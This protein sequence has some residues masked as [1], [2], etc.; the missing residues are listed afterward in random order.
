LVLRTDLSGDPTFAELLE[1]IRE[2]AL[3]AYAH[4]DLPFEKLVEELAIE[5][6]L[7]H[8]PA[9]QVMFVLQNTPG[10]DLAMSGLAPAALA[11]PTNEVSV[12]VTMDLT[13]TPDGLVASLVYNADLFDEA[14]ME[15]LLRHYRNVL[16]EVTADAGTPLGRVALL[17]DDEL[18]TLVEGFNPQPSPYPSEARVQEVLERLAA[19]RPDAVAVVYEDGT[20]TYGELNARANALARHLVDSGVERGDLVAVALDRGPELVTALLAVLKTGAAYLPIDPEH[21]RRRTSF[22]MDDA[23]AR[24]LL[25]SDDLAGTFDAGPARVVS[26]GGDAAAIAALSQDDLG[27]AGDSEDVAYAIYTSGSTGTPKGICIPH[28]AITRLVLDTDY[29]KLGPDS[30]VAQASN[31]SFDAATFE[32][33][34][35]LLNGGR[36]VGIPKD[37]LLDARRL[38]AALE[39]HDVGVM[40]VTTALFNQLVAEDPSLF[41]V[42]DTLLFGG[43]AVDPG[44]VRRCVEEG[45]PRELLHVY[46]PTESTTFTTWHR[47]ESVPDGSA[48]IPIGRPLANTRVHILDPAMNPVPAGVTGEIHIGGAGLATGY[49][50]RPELT[51]ERFVPDPLS[52]GPSALLYRTGDL[53]RYLPS[54]EIEFL[55]RIDSQVKIRGFRV[56][57]G[58]I[59]TVM[60]EH[61]AVAEAVV[62]VASG[63][64]GDRRLIGYV[65]AGADGFDLAELRRFLTERIPFYMVPSDFVRLDAFPLNANGKIDRRALPAPEAAQPVPEVSAV[66]PRT[67]AEATMAQIWAEVLRRESIGVHENFFALGGDSIVSLRLASR[68]RRGFGVDGSPRELFEAPTVGALAERLHDLILAKFEA[69][70]N[71]AGER[72]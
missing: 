40:F 19:E 61:P 55:G 50:N 66:A 13:E 60:A 57:L 30:V 29:V 18:R 45:P 54:G 69:A 59:E 27:L 10:A 1:R 68:V 56:E 23:E 24:I 38:R 52:G 25:T 70:A 22:M 43:E 9:V 33:W 65:V 39:R 63:T 48:T 34:G 41:S 32:I 37:V 71:R 7:A 51:K 2:V 72:N 64:G 36:L 11:A 67:A 53:A 26:L 62:T 31:A 15:R 20:L 44:M 8:S 16:A 5:R 42:L 6:D 46:G 4:Q 21:P 49:L 28:R 35:P 3:G 12:D 58:E 14:T 47:V 17:D